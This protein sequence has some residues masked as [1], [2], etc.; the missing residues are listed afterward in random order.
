MMLKRLISVLL[1]I[2]IISPANAISIGKYDFGWDDASVGAGVATVVVAG[3][4]LI[5]APVTVP[6]LA[7]CAVAAG[8]VA[9]AG[10][11]I[12]DADA[13]ADVAATGGEQ[14]SNLSTASYNREKKITCWIY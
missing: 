10:Y 3:A 12:A 8:A 7:A 14:V 4:I 13:D 6:T 2:S 9:A 1:L 5:S 11:C